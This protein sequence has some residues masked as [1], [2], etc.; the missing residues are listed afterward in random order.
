VKSEL[1]PD[2]CSLSPPR[3]RNGKVGQVMEFNRASTVTQYMYYVALTYAELY[4]TLAGLF[5]VY[6][7][8]GLRGAGDRGWLQL[9]ETSFERDVEIVGDGI[10]PLVRRGI[11]IKVRK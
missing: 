9:W 1:D 3:F 10:T 11:R 7:S 5:R 8:E 4:L 2:F 6:G